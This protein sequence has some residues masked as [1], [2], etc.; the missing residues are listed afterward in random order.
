MVLENFFPATDS[1][2]LALGDVDFTTKVIDAFKEHFDFIAG[3]NLF[4]VFEFAAMHAAFALQAKLDDDIIAGFANN[5]PGHE[6]TRG[7]GVGNF[8]TKDGIHDVVLFGVTE[9]FGEVLFDIGINVADGG[10]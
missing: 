6:F 1:I 9:G 2:C 10:D 5:G 8:A 3:G 4:P 7:G